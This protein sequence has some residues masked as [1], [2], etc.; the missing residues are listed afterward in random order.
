MRICM[1]IFCRKKSEILYLFSHSQKFEMETIKI[2][3]FSSN[4]KINAN[5]EMFRD[6]KFYSKYEILKIRKTFE[7]FNFFN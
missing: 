6:K 2:C 1:E 4:A 7:K 5:F 3:I